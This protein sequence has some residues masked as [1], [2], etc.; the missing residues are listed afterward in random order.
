MH[1]TSEA[2]DS[3]MRVRG[4]LRGNFVRDAIA[5]GYRYGI[6]G[7]GDSHDGH[8]GLTFYTPHYFNGG[9]VALLTEELTRSGV[10]AALRERRVYATNGPRIVLRFALAGA[11]MGQATQ[12]AEQADLYVYALG[13]APIERIDV[14]RSG[15]VVATLP[16]DGQDEVEAS[17]ELQDLRPGEFVYVRI[18]QAGDGLA[19][20]S[21]VFIE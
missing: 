15:S 16:G 17:A 19:W 2:E 7:S 18:E 3:P 20:S 12:A 6:I 10:E 9:L 14:I 13:T 21:P 8:P 1:G 11:V 4:A 5:R